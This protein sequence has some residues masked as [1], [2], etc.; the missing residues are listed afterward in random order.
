MPRSLHPPSPIPRPP[1]ASPASS[2]TWS[3][4]QRGWL[5]PGSHSPHSG[6]GGSHRPGPDTGKNLSCPHLSAHTVAM[7]T[8]GQSPHPESHFAPADTHQEQD[9]VTQG[10]GR[11]GTRS[12]GCGDTDGESWPEFG[13]RGPWWGVQKGSHRTC[14]DVLGP[15]AHVGAVLERAA[16]LLLPVPAAVRVPC[17]QACPAGQRSRDSSPLDSHHHLHPKNTPGHAPLGTSFIQ[18][19]STTITKFIEY[20]LCA[21]HRFKHFRSMN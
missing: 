7:V 17:P 8:M 15:Q 6:V 1:P 11:E 12:Q 19:S 13:G 5:A 18:L 14:C 9:P 4:W 10:R 16:T 21:R 3:S 2:H 20:L